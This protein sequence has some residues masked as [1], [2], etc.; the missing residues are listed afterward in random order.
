M[1]LTDKEIKALTPDYIGRVRKARQL[2]KLYQKFVLTVSDNTNLLSI[3]HDIALVGI[4]M[5]RGKSNHIIYYG[6]AL[7][8]WIHIQ[9][10]I[11]ACKNENDLM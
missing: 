9:E 7:E 6:S 4:L 2:N 1:F 3:V 11:A 5:I 10:K 8:L